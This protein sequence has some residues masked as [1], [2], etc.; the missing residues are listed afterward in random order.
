MQSLY[1][2]MGGHQCDM[3]TKFAVHYQACSWYMMR[4]QDFI[5][6]KVG[7][8]E[9]GECVGQCQAFLDTASTSIADPTVEFLKDFASHLKEVGGCRDRLRQGAT[10][11][12]ERGLE[13]LLQQGWQAWAGHLQSEKTEK[14]QVLAMQGFFSEASLLFPVSTVVTQAVEGV[15]TW[16]RDF[17]ASSEVAEFSKRCIEWAKVDLFAPDA[18]WQETVHR[19][20]SIASE[21]RR[22]LST[23]AAALE[24]AQRVFKQFMVPFAST[25]A[26]PTVVVEIGEALLHACDDIGVRVV[27]RV[28]R[29]L[30]EVAVYVAQVKVH[31]A[32][33]DGGYDAAKDISDQEESVKEV[34][35]MLEKHTNA[36]ATSLQELHA[37][38]GP[39]LEDFVLT[40]SAFLTEV[41]TSMRALRIQ[42]REAVSQKAAAA[43]DALVAIAKGGTNGEAWEDSHKGGAG[44]INTFTAFMQ[45]AEAKLLTQDGDVLL[46]AIESMEKACRDCLCLH[47]LNLSFV[48]T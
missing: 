28:D 23:N 21:L 27:E 15:A 3:R 10:D 4:M 43:Y 29:A 9:C 14:A 32:A 16:L 33:F 40:S 38:A 12:A 24:S 22:Y 26:Q 35:R 25:E 20:G 17:A 11:E 42:E 5:D 7:M 39:E 2:C 8:L 18:P 13:E 30:V 47:L 41:T 34:M 1:D 36:L 48:R 6:N 31:S 44:G 37:C 46:G 45:H 19:L